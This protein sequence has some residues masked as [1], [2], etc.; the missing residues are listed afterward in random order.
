MQVWPKPNWQEI[1][2][3]LTRLGSIQ[4]LP[5]LSIGLKNDQ[6]ISIRAFQTNADKIFREGE[7]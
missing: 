7:K 4:E 2:I 5:N 1:I 3:R 6:P